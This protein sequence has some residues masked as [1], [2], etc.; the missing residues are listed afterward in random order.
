MNALGLPGAS[1]DG[2][3]GF[4]ALARFKIELDPTDDRMT[5]TRLAFEPLDPIVPKRPPGAKPPGEMQAMNALGAVAKVAAA[6]VGKQPEDELLPRRVPR[7][8]TR[9]PARG[10][11]CPAPPRRR[12][13]SS[14]TIGFPR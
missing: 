7:H 14:S 4:T 11:S 6:L 9:R 1:I 2:L 10:A 8:R 3:L 13:E 12:P 5:W